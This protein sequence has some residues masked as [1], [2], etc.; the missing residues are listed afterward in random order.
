MS[1]TRRRILAVAAVAQSSLLG[2]CFGL[3]GG[4]ESNNTPAGE[5]SQ[6]TATPTSQPTTTEPT[7]TAAPTA[8]PAHAT[9]D[10]TTT[11]IVEEFGWFR[12]D[13]DAA[14]S[15]FQGEVNGVFGAL[16][17]LE[18]ADQLTQEDVATL[19][20]QTT[21]VAE[22]MQANLVDHFAVAPALRIGNNVFVRDLERAVERGDRE[23]QRSVL[24]TTRNFYQRV[25]SQP[26]ITNEFSQRPVY[27][28]LYEMLIPTD[29]DNRIVALASD[30]GEFIT[31][32]HPDR[33]DSTADDGVP[34]HTHEFPSGH[35]VF[36]HAHEHSTGHQLRDH[37]NEPELN[38]L[39]A[40]GD[41][42]VALLRDAESWRER[43]DDYDPVYT[44][45][46]GPVKS[47]AREEGIT[48]FV[49]T[50]DANFTA[51]PLYVERF[52]SVTAAEE[53]VAAAEEGAVS[54]QGTATFA[55]REWDRIIYDLEGTTIYAYRLH[56][57]ETVI[58]ALPSDVP[59]ERRR[60]WTG[61]L[62]ATWLGAESA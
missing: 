37:T 26:Y 42:G 44:G 21:S 53:A 17:E 19:R 39:Y 34:Q 27:G 43:L 40:Y 9:L 6:N 15:G 32:A 55:G 49:G 52:A 62:E 22:Y 14:I 31:W 41:D 29:A 16:K 7:E 20:E 38:E 12:T 30:D 8:T 24:A 36:T 5:S 13:Y 18:S 56:A 2:G 1:T 58:S 54:I 57:G 60:D 61:G 25:I 46:F 35:Q 28:P 50:T 59:W 10:T 11:N 4:G 33:T 51:S 3:F 45:L 47:D 48:L 23:L